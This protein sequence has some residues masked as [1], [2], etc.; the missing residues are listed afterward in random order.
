M[1]LKLQAKVEGDVD[2]GTL[3]TRWVGEKDVEGV[4]RVRIE[5]SHIQ[6]SWATNYD[7][8]KYRSTQFRIIE[9]K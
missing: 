6:N 3:N 4:A 5:L 2:W 8:F 9:E 1:K 7:R